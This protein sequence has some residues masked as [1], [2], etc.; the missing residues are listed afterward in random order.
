M[1][2]RVAIAAAAAIAI[3]G[4]ATVV[5]SSLPQPAESR[6]GTV[7]RPIDPRQQTAVAFGERSHWLQPWRGYLDTPP[8]TKLR[9]AIGIQLNVDPAEAE[10]TARLLAHSGFR[11][12]RV[13]FGWDSV[14]YSNTRR[15]S[16][17]D[18]MRTTLRALKTHRLRPLILL[19]AHHGAPGPIRPFPATL[20]APAL[21]GERQVRLSPGT[22]R[23]VVP[24]RTG[25]NS[26]DGKAADVLFTA[27][28]PGGTA[29]LS[30][31]L[32]R[33]MPAGEHP[34]ATLRFAPFGPPRLQDGRPNPRFERTLR[35]W[36]QY[37][38]AIIGEARAVL[39]SDRFDLEVWNELSFGSDFLYQERYYDPPRERGKGEV[40]E[41]ILRRT[42]DAV[43]RLS[44][45]IGIGNGFANQS[46][47][48]AGSTSPRGLTALD[49]HP[50]YAIKRFPGGA[51]YDGNAPLNALGRH[52]FDEDRL[53]GDKLLRTDTFTPRYDSLFPEY[54]LT[55]IQTEHLIRDLSPLTTDVY[56]TPH[57]R[58]THPPRGKPP[59]VWI[60]ESSVDPTGADPSDPANPGSG[61]I[62]QL[63]PR[64][65][66]H[67]HAKAA[68]R[69]YTAFTNKGVSAVHL[70]AA[71][72]E[73][74]SLVNP[75][76]FQRLARGRGRYPGAR[77]GGETPRAVRRLTKALRGAR[78]LGSTQPLSLLSVSDDHGHIQFE[79]DGTAAHPPLYDRDVLA[80]FPFQLRPGRWVAAVYVMSRNL[81]KLYGDGYDKPPAAFRLEIGG[82][83][84]RR[85]RLSAT[86]PLTGAS[87]PV[88]VVSRRSTAVS[89]E[90]PVTD[91]PRLL[92][93]AT[94]R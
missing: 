56:G 5:A 92:T 68:L 44:P 61:P 40:T 51:V 35:G 21:R 86:D 89:V 57:G 33:D 31:P 36:L 30:K 16:K 65:V 78:H 29:T 20:K 34:A 1:R 22:A 6:G 37:V 59:Q 27:V 55:A 66:Q 60:T 83:A 71:K 93:L 15:L 80:F 49:K 82:L 91:S 63:T 47:F 84:G 70:F 14:A 88:R 10:S 94:R 45:R 81:A 42:V 39:G 62:R 76:F 72:G 69:Y 17:R 52:D 28:R 2:K 90:L 3:L 7:V 18:E 87:V 41:E 64:D 85:V 26:A 12:A 58:K 53:P 75:A 48:P 43:R 25:L 54:P 24:G 4:A 32:P 73:P 79:G 74:F 38:R 9:D 23:R 11:R 50:Y 67:L 8:A 13:E 19:N 46:P 77:A